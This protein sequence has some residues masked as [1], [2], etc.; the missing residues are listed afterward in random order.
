[1]KKSEIEKE[2]SRKF[3]LNSIESRKVLDVII[4]A[5]T[6]MLRDGERIEI[7]HFGSFFT[8]SYDPYEGRNPRTGE[9]INIG[10]KILPLFRVSSWLAPKLTEKASDK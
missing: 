4:N 8:K 1:M 7:R 2:L 10:K 6:E 9:K 3:D 5:M